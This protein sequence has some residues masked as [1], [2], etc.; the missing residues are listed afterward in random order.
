MVGIEDTNSAPLPQ[1]WWLIGNRPVNFD[2]RDGLHKGELQNA[3]SNTTP[4]R[5]RASRFGVIA[6]P[7][8]LQNASGNAAIWSASI[9]RMFGRSGTGSSSS[10]SGRS[11]DRLMSRSVSPAFSSR[12]L[13]RVGFPT[14]P[15]SAIR[16]C[17]SDK[18]L[19]ALPNHVNLR[20]EYLNSRSGSSINMALSWR[21]SATLVRR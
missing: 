7:S 2:A 14:V 10:Q 21:S 1:T 11:R 17:G 20:C 15:V 19:G 18:F 12:R 6:C 9:N 16:Q 8:R 4:S 3:F 5:A 13:E